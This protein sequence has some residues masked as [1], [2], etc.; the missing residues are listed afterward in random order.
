MARSAATT[1]AAYLDELPAER[2]TVVAAV[3]DVILRRL[4]AGYE[5][6]M[7][8]GMI[9]Y[10][11]PLARYPDTYNKQPLA[12]AALAAQKSYYALY[13]TCAYPGEAV[14]RALPLAR[15]PAARRDRRRRREHAA[16][17]VHRAVRGGAA[18]LSGARRSGASAGSSAPR[19]SVSIVGRKWSAHRASTRSAGT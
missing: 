6:T 19:S 3:R 12:Y 11:V 18:A 14:V 7:N 5:E 10:E 4:P 9:A 13:L 15:R 17:G 8:W 16:G 1:V 2:R